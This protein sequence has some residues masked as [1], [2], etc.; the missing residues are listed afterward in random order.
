MTR[1]VTAILL[2]AFLFITGCH[3]YADSATM[4]TRKDSIGQRQSLVPYD[5]FKKSFINRIDTSS[6]IQQHQLL[7]NTLADTIPMYWFGTKWDYNGITNVPKQ[8]AIACGYF[9]C[10]VLSHLGFNIP[11]VKYSQ[12]PSSKMINELCHNIK[13]F[14]SHAAFVKYL[15][16]YEGTGAFIVGLDLHTGF[17]VKATDKS[18]SF[19]HSFFLYRMGV[20][21]DDIHTSLSLRSS[22]GFMLG[23]LTDSKKLQNTFRK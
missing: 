1:I 18:S 6:P 20:I 14:N 3:S 16:E 5:S 15:D 7:V 13:R 9:V 11:V 17:I 19:I 10:R 22:N 23:E 12:A 4:P 21:K 2:N 8:G